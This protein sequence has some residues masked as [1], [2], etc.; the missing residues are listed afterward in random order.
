MPFFAWEC[1]TIRFSHR[2]VDLV[3]KSEADQNQFAKYL[4]Y[5]LNTIDGSLNSAQPLLDVLEEQ[6][7][8]KYCK[9][10]KMKRD[11]FKAS[12]ASSFLSKVRY[13]NKL[14]LMRKTYLK[15]LII[16]LRIKIS[17]I[18]FKKKMTLVELICNSILKTYN[19]L[20]TKGAIKVN[21]RI[22]DINNEIY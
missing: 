22:N 15:Y 10:K 11:N 8:L 17:F 6:A 3:F 2:D 20:V 16:K 21:E 9:S 18:A 13:K 7:I 12:T 4:I 5:T 1:L 14:K 19:L